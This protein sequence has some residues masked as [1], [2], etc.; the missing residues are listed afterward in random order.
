VVGSVLAAALTLALM[1][2]GYAGATLAL[3]RAELT[4]SG[5]LGARR[6]LVRI[7]IVAAIVLLVVA[8]V[9]TASHSAE[10]LAVCLAV[11]AALT[12]GGTAVWTAVAKG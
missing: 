2:L 8:I 5:P 4:P 9:L 10:T 3:D 6:S 12:A 1:S 7:G 11:A